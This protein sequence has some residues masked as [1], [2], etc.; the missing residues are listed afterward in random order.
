MEH[1]TGVGIS[2]ELDLVRSIAMLLPLINAACPGR[3]W[4]RWIQHV[5]QSPLH[6]SYTLPVGT[7]GAA[8]PEREPAVRTIL[9]CSAILARA[10]QQRLANNYFG[11][12]LLRQ[13]M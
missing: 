13:S 9:R 5:E 12:W 11:G 3:G 6:G 1:Y 2:V 8:T 7:C 10:W 4:I